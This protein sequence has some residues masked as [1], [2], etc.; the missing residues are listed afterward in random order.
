M[1]AVVAHGVQGSVM[2]LLGSLTVCRKGSLLL[3]MSQRGQ[4]TPAYLKMR[5]TCR[6][7]LSLRISQQSSMTR[8]VRS[9]RSSHSCSPAQAV[10][11]PRQ[12]TTQMPWCRY[13]YRLLQQQWIQPPLWPVQGGYQRR[14]PAAAASLAYRSQQ[15]MPFSTLTVGRAA[16][17]VHLSF[18]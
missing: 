7:I 16:R 12:Q 17:S 18:S 3:R 2:T 8:L 13:Q 11:Q 14:L 6:Q 9:S 4:M 15:W 10:Q 1:I 5:K